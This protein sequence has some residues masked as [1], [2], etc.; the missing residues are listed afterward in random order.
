[1]SQKIDSPV[2][3]SQSTGP[4]DLRG[5]GGFTKQQNYADTSG[6]SARPTRLGFYLLGEVLVRHL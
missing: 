6:E 5:P 1:M 2:L 3:E 4:E